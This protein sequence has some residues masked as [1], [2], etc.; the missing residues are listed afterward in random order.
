MAGQA[1]P[2]YGV[3]NVAVE[4]DYVALARQRGA[5]LYRVVADHREGG[6]GCVAHYIDESRDAARRRA[7]GLALCYRAS[8]ATVEEID[9]TSGEAR[10]A[11]ELAS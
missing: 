5:F 3:S 11:Q 6:R 4:R 9:V 10:P 7:F 2:Q 8:N 1:Q